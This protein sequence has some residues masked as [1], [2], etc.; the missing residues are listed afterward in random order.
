MNG[1]S[2]LVQ[3]PVHLDLRFLHGRL[4]GVDRV[5][6]QVA[7]LLDARSITALV[8]FNPLRLQKVAEVTEEFVF[9][10]G[11]HSSLSKLT[12]NVAAR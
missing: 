7:A 6:K 1:L 9:F 5:R 11:L 8:Q 3:G 12:D 2:E 10:D 4:G